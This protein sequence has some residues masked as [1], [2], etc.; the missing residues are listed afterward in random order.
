MT[1]KVLG[2]KRVSSTL[3]KKPIVSPGAVKIK[4]QMRKVTAIATPT[5]Q[6]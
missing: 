1:T 2:R 4:K 6:I 5:E 3:N